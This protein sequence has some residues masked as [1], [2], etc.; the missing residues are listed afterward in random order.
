MKL[1]HRQSARIA[2]RAR[3]EEPSVRLILVPPPRDEPD[4][5]GCYLVQDAE[6]TIHSTGSTSRREALRELGGL[7]MRGMPAPLLLLSPH[8]APTGDRLA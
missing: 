1:R 7:A 2:T 3:D 4:L 5:T 8:G 6:G